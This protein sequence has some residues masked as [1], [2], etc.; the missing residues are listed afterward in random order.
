MKQMN[1]LAHSAVER[2]REANR[3]EVEANRLARTFDPD[4]SH[5]AA[6]H[7]VKSGIVS[8]QKARVLD[9]LRSNPRRTTNELAALGGIDRHVVGRRMSGL[10]SDGLVRRLDK[11]QCQISGR[12]AFTWEVF[13]GHNEEST[14]VCSNS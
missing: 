2:R 14:L 10:E 13:G 12:T 1:L 6:V 4:T 3:R 5:E 9:A 11:R 7:V 8:G